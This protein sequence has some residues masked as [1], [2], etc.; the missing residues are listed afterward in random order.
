[1]IEHEQRLARNQRNQFMWVRLGRWMEM[2]VHFGTPNMRLQVPNRYLVHVTVRFGKRL[3]YHGPIRLETSGVRNV[4]CGPAVASRVDLYP[5]P[6]PLS[7][8]IQKIRGCVSD[9]RLEAK[10]RTEDTT[11]RM[12]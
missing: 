8:G 4:E 5:D 9:A 1:M 10:N 11:I 7:W 12:A 2:G 3:W 6:E